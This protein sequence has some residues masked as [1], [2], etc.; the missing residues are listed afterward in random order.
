MTIEDRLRQAMAEEAASV[1][2]PPDRWAAI[3]RRAAMARRA[4]GRRTRQ[5]RTGLTLV[6]VAAAAL[7]VAAVSGLFGSPSQRVGTTPGN[8]PATTAAPGTVA[9][10]T[11]T[12]IGGGGPGPRP[13]S[14]T[15]AS[16]PPARTFSY[17]P[18]WPFR[19]LSEVQAWQAA[20]RSGGA[21]P[22]HLDAAQSAL[23]FSRGF[24]G[25]QDIDKSYGITN[26]SSGAHVTVGF[27]N[28]NGQPVKA[29]VIH[30]VRFGTGADAPWEVV[31]TDDGPD[32]SL[33]TPGYGTVASSPLAVGGR[34]TGADENIKVQVR[35]QSST[36]AIGVSVPVP[37]GGQGSPWKSTVAYQGAS[38]AVLT[39]AASTGGHLAEVERFTVTGVRTSA[40]APTA[41]L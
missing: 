32:F 15:T 3:E 4:A 14:A 30:L 9:P 38:D 13:G 29:A 19:S 2:A 18:L 37:A 28:P 1:P 16:R 10:G 24:L 33:T 20:Y 7:T 35:Q 39:V 6:G 22:W 25:Y 34:I 41:G 21:Q 31:G 17:Q 40:T 27:D 8:R 23:D 26:D 36:Q 12:T 5:W 11:P